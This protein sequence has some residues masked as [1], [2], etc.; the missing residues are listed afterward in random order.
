MRAVIT[1]H[2]MYCSSTV[3]NWFRS[4]L[5]FWRSSYHKICCFSLLF[6]SKSFCLW[7]N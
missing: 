7:W 2:L 5:N 3:S 6:L 4:S 1:K